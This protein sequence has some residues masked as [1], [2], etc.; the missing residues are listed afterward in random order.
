M[1]TAFQMEPL[2]AV[3]D[4]EFST[5]LLLLQEGLRRGYEVYQF[6]PLDLSLRE[7]QLTAKAYQVREL[8]LGKTPFF[9]IDDAKRVNLAEF[10]AI[11]MRQ[12]PPF[13]IEYITATFLLEKAKTLV[14]NNPASVRNSVEKFFPL[15][16]PEFIPPTLISADF[17]EISEFKVKYRE[18]I[19][20]PIYSFGGEGVFLVR[21][22]RNLAAL[23]ET[24]VRHY[25][26]PMVIQQYI[27]QIADGEKR[28]I[29]IDG[30]LKGGLLKI[31]PKGEVRA[32]LGHGG[33]PGKAELSARDLAIA[34]TVGKELKKR[35]IILA[36]LD[37]I[38]DYL[39]EIN[40]TSP[41]GLV[42]FT[43]LYNV[44]LEKDYWDAVERICHSRVGGNP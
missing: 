14:V 38:G 1:K 43:S 27:P 2:S 44:A 32:N 33:R 8:D 6:A 18:I 40:V 29:L 19:I 42:D 21:E 3:T 20:K 25:Q 24:L 17:D 16:F 36:A 31:P 22:S 26:T 9:G 12:N 23:I 34:A 28:L 15:D 11:H 7:G 39:T 30:E 41:S 37:I 10:S 35:G 13:N 4:K 5:T